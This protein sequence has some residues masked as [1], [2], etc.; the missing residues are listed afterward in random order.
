MK[1]AISRRDFLGATAGAAASATLLGISFLDA[2]PAQATSSFVRRDVGGMSA[3]DPVLVSYGKAVQAMQA[4][5]NT[6]PLSWA[7]QAAIHGTTLSGSNTAWDTCQ[8][9]NYFFWSWHRMYL[10]WFERI[11][12]KMADDPCWSLPYWNYTSTAERTLPTPFRD[13]TSP[14]FTSNRGAGWNTG[15]ASFPSGDVQYSAALSL[16]NFTNGSSSVEQSPHNNVHVD[17]GGL[18]GVIDTA[19]QDP[20]FFLHHSNIDRLWDIWLAQTPGA[21]DPLG[22]TT[23]KST[24]F[25]FFDENGNQVQMTGCEVLRAQQQL[26]YS[27]EGEPA[28]VSPKCLLIVLPPWVFTEEVFAQLPGPPVELTGETVSFPINLAELRKR[29][30]LVLEDKNKTIFLQLDEV[31]TEKPPGVVWDVFVGLPEKAAPDTESPY[32]V[33]TLAMFGPGI[34]SS[35]HHNEPAHFSFPVSRALAAA[36]KTDSERTAV[37]FVPHGVLINGKPS[38][39]EVKSP[40]RIGKAKLIVETKEENKKQ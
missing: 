20:I 33:G 17:I 23:W 7:Y 2:L 40:V 13:A 39:P 5:P 29:I 32:F 3:T 15:A 16:S 34:R 21:G 31:E 4:L 26:G 22:D 11:I 8:H 19:A 1:S 27:Y 37:T 30:A 36:L 38:R 9:G 28:Q 24:Q 14:L 18:M 25:T 12:R 10:Y 6:N 35:K